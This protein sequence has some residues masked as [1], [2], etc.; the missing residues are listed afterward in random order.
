MSI[1]FT[2]I[3]A[4]QEYV[5]SLGCVIIVLSS[6]DMCPIQTII[7]K[8]IVHCVPLLI[9]I[10]NECFFPTETLPEVIEDVK[11]KTQCNCGRKG[12]SIGCKKACP[13]ALAKVPCGL[14]CHCLKCG[15]DYGP[16]SKSQP[17]KACTCRGGCIGNRCDCHKF[18]YSCLED[19]R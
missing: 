18:G 8:N 10:G 11:V 12:K 13:C 15:N 17:K 3:A 9:G 19:P 14:D 2:D 1:N 6:H 4:M 5:D 16:R 7:P